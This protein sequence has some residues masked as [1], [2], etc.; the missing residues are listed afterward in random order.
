MIFYTGAVLM[1]GSALLGLLGAVLLKIKGSRLRETLNRE[2]GPRPK[3][4][5]TFQPKREKSGT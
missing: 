5:K 3:R 2:Y 1:G 4:Q